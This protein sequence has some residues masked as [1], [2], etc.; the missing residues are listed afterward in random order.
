MSQA[1][2]DLGNS[3]SRQSC[4]QIGHA[5]GKSQLSK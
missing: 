1:E 4:V 5:E 2:M 3:N